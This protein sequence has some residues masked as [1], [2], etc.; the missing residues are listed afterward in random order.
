MK[1]FNLNYS[2]FLLLA[3]AVCSCSKE[4]PQGPAGDDG[5]YTQGSI[6]G[7]A[8][9]YNQFGLEVLTDKNNI[10][11]TVEGSNPVISGS[12]NDKGKVLLKNIPFG[13]YYL[14]A[15][16][17]GYEKTLILSFNVLGDSAV[18]T[19][20]I[21]N[22]VQRSNVKYSNLVVS[23]A[24]RYSWYFTFNTDQTKKDDFSLRYFLSTSAQVSRDNY[25]YTDVK[26][27]SNSNQIMNIYQNSGIFSFASG[28]KLYIC[29]YGYNPK[30]NGYTNLQTGL[31]EYP[32]LSD[33][34]TNVVELIMP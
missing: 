6:E 25:L 26:N 12:T 14:L 9:A 4:G 17:E 21:V 22:L 33:T 23:S 27:S 34:G 8:S 1:I 5:K 28:T 19:F 2:I 16:K 29:F 11:F 30:D 20:G 31:M 15:S 3:V 24:I 10:T 32:S 13:T 18:N 7:Y